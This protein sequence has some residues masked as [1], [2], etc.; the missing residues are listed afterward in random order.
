[1]TDDDVERE[2]RYVCALCFNS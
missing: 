2:V 1:M